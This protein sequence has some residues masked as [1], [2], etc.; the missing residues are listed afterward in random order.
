M[1]EIHLHMSSGVC[2]VRASAVSEFCP[3]EDQDP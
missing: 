1:E 3:L 2:D